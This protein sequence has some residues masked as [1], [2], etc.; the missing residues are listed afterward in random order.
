MSE[1]LVLIAPNEPRFHGIGDIP[2]LLRDEY[3]VMRELGSGTRLEY[4]EMLKKIG[5]RPAELKA[6]VYLNNTQSIINAVA[7]GLGLSFV[8]ELAA[9]PFIRQNLIIPIDVGGLPERNFYIVLK[10]SCPIA[11]VTD[12][13]VS[14]VRAW[15]SP[16]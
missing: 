4:E 3:F 1:K 6:S 16:P 8:S 12:A 15:A 7:N 14:F 9:R 13:F 10:K 11:P 2:R 5:V